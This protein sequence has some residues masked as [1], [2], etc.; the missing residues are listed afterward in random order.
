MV[1]DEQLA[2]TIIGFSPDDG[3]I[4]PAILADFWMRAFAHWRLLMAAQWSVALLSEVRLLPTCQTPGV[5][6][7]GHPPPLYPSSLSLSIP[8][9]AH[10]V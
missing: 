9:F 7:S 10:H 1:H 5:F 8:A 3:E 4:W 6:P 2:I